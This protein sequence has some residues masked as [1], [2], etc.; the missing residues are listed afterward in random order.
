ML[1]ESAERLLSFCV[2]VKISKLP[3][4]DITQFYDNVGKED[5]RRQG[6]KGERILFQ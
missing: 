4:I 2:A 6:A 3:G 1:I 5:N